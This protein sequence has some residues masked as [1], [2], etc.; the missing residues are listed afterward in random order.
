MSDN[1]LALASRVTALE[2]S[3]A[4]LQ[5]RLLDLDTASLQA[6]QAIGAAER[7]RAELGD[8]RISELSL[9]R[10]TVD[11][12]IAALALKIVNQQ[13][14][15]QESAVYS[16]VVATQDATLPTYSYSIV[17]DGQAIAADIST[18]VQAG[19]VIVA[20]LTL[21]DEAQAAPSN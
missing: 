5:S 15:L 4:D 11:G 1:G 7:E 18:K 3:V 13:A 8:T 16:G 17:R 2:T 10:Q 6:R 9:E 19:D 21:S 12:Q 20:R 14:L